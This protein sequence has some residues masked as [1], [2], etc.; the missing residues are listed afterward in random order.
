VL[1][2]QYTTARSSSL[3][4]RR[5]PKRSPCSRTPKDPKLCLRRLDRA[6]KVYDLRR[7]AAHPTLTLSFSASASRG[8]RP[9]WKPSRW[10]LD[11]LR[12]GGVPH[13]G[14]GMGIERLVEAECG[15]PQLRL[16]RSRACWTKTLTR[17]GSRSDKM[18]R[19]GVPRFFFFLSPARQL[20]RL[21]NC[22]P[23]ALILTQ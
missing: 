21:K 4:T 10:Y 17:N 20:Q 19:C 2:S 6:K 1:A 22:H 15:V 13:S 5:K 3:T 9:L 7:L 14:F 11:S 18:K 23:A 12:Y 16:F 8:A